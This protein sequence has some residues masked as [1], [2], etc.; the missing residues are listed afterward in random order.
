MIRNRYP[1]RL[2]NMFL[3]L[4]VGLGISELTE[5]LG[6]LVNGYTKGSKMC[7]ENNKRQSKEAC[8]P[9]WK[10]ISY[11]NVEHMN[12]LNGI[13]NYVSGQ[14]K[15]VDLSVFKSVES[16]HGCVIVSSCFL[17]L[18]FTSSFSPNH[19]SSPMVYDSKWC[20]AR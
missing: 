11:A 7:K 2:K 16:M 18:W 17:E 10:D 19:V 1:K 14:V 6:V 9:K 3:K 5:A 4:M 12:G 13:A 8:K 20:F 15:R